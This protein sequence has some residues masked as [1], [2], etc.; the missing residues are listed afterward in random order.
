MHLSR[1]E[2]SDFAFLI[3][4]TGRL[5]LLRR[6]GAITCEVSKLSVVVAWE[7]NWVHSLLWHPNLLLSLWRNRRPSYL[8][9]L[10]WLRWPI[11]PLLLWWPVH[12]L[13][14][15]G[16]SLWPRLHEAEPLWVATSGSRCRCLSFLFCFM[17]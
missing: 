6:H 14:L 1:F 15:E 8:L 17:S 7:Q 4:L 3:L 11:S 2:V 9:W 5:S 10:W 12:R 16:G 13:V